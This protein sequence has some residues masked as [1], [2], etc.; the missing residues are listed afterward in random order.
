M[1]KRFLFLSWLTSFVTDRMFSPITSTWQGGAALASHT[2]TLKGLLVT[3]QDYLEHGATWT[4][5]QYQ[6]AGSKMQTVIP[7]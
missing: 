6:S 5:R 4:A 3:R 7:P 1:S 2:D